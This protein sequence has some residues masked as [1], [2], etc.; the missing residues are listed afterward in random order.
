M[1]SLLIIDDEPFICKG[2]HAKISR[3][4]NPK[5]THI[6]ECYDSIEA[7]RLIKAS[8]PDIVITDMKMPNLSGLELIQ[9]LDL[10]KIK[11]KFLVLS[12]HDDYHY[13]RESF[14][15]GVIDYLLKPINLEELSEQLEHIVKLLDSGRD[16]QSILDKDL[17]TM[18][19]N[20]ALNTSGEAKME[21]YQYIQ[22]KLGK[23]F[24]QFA[25]VTLPKSDNS[26]ELSEIVT[27]IFDHF[28]IGVTFLG[29]Y[30]LH[31]YIIFI[32]NYDDEKLQLTIA[33]YLVTRLRELKRD[34]FY[35]IKIA[36]T[37][38]KDSLRDI[39]QLFGQLHNILN[40]RIVYE[41]Y[42]LMLL[43]T[44][45]DE[46]I[47]NSE[48]AFYSSINQWC[49]T[50]NYSALHTF[51]DSYFVTK[52]ISDIDFH[53]MKKT[54][55]YLLQKMNTLLD[56][57]NPIGI[58]LFSKTYDAFETMTELRIYLKDCLFKLQH[59]IE[60]VDHQG[61]TLIDSAITYINSHLHEEL[62][63]LDVC[64]HL[65]INYSYFSKLFKQTM[66]ISFKKYL[67]QARMEKAKK[68]MHNPTNRIYEIALQVGYENAQNFSRA[69][70]GHFG[71]S[72]KEYR[73]NTESPSKED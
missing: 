1:Y 27:T 10:T 71:Y 8:P 43:D 40:T 63:M 57:S 49:F 47:T 45:T 58:D 67:I 3:I 73:N 4:N 72:P 53:A 52:K 44:L 28:P 54:Y 11:S 65:S 51:I 35:N 22:A 42:S 33:N 48:T 31:H 18:I 39:N 21:A 70:K 9:S 38:C 60:S 46:R 19:N 5:I 55:L 15:Y 32:F 23:T 34:N 26:L 29:Y 66:S 68:L 12:G 25:A 36:L 37:S 7:L 30:D 2:I 14:H 50:K 16:H 41:P 24:Y 17:G 61:I 13:V 6:Q 64:T 59:H 56:S 62:S 69:F 20:L